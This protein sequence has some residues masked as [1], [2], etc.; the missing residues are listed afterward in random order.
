MDLFN[1]DSTITN[2]LPYDGVVEYHGSIMSATSAKDYFQI[3][4]DT[5]PWKHDELV[6][7]GRHISTKR[8]VAWYGDENYSY[9]YSHA[10]KEAL[11]W[12]KELLELKVLAEK[13]SGETFNSCLLNLYHSGEEGMTWHSDD[14]KSLVENACIAS[15][16]FGA[17]RVFSF[18]HKTTKVVV[19]QFLGNGSLLLMKGATQ[20][21]W[22]HALPKTKKSTFPRIN[23]TFRLMVE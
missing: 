22:Q 16:S 15:L 1:Q 7:Y 14:E 13:I 8:K 9:T 3:L 20:K 10:T 11:P 5:I 19:T 21:F 6:M 2:L 4:L 17:E 12:T 23:L 18:R